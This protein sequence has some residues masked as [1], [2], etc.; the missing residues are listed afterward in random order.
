MRDNKDDKVVQLADYMVSCRI[1]EDDEK[2]K[3]VVEQVQTHHH[4]N[5]CRKYGTDCRYNFDR[6]PSRHTIVARPLDEEMDEK[7]KERKVGELNNLFDVHA[8]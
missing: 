4:T 7:K 2:F 8:P 5:S 6:Y 3:E 1:P